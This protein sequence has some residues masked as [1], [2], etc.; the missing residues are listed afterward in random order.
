MILFDVSRIYV[1]PIEKHCEE[2]RSRLLGTAF[3]VACIK[4]LSCK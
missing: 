3:F 4:C 2:G 1:S